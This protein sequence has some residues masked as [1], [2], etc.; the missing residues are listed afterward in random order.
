MILLL[1]GTSEAGPLALRLAELGYSVLVSQATSVPMAL[2]AH[3]RIEQRTG[4]LDDRAL[5]ELVRVRR[6]RAVLDATH[7]YATQAHATAR[8]VAQRLGLV[9]VRYVRPRSVTG[10]RPGVQ[11]A[12]T[13]EQAAQKA[14]ALGRPV[15]LTIGS[16]RLG[17]YVQESR[18]TGLTLFARV[19]DDPA[20]IQACRAAGLSL[21]QII[22][23]R[24]PFHEADNRALIRRVAAGVLVTKDGGEAGG[25]PAKLRA[26]EAEACQVVAVARP[27]AADDDAVGSFEEFVQSL[28]QKLGRPPGDQGVEGK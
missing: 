14:F 9:Y 23:G 7:P 17:P 10:D 1:G 6:I 24:G 16:R 5:A 3:P 13:H 22:T 11:L 15:L 28:R 27:S 8:S 25:V 26:A 20:S 21:D 18:R 4:P 12:A 19:L 2:P